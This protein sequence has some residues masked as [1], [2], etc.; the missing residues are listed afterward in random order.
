MHS[1][2]RN[3]H[4]HDYYRWPDG[5]QKAERD[6]EAAAELA[7][8]GGGSE[9]SPLIPA[10]LDEEFPGFVDATATEPPKQLLRSMGGYS[11]ADEEPCDQ[12]SDVHV[13]PDHCDRI[14]VTAN[15]AAPASSNQCRAVSITF[16]ETTPDPA[17]GSTVSAAPR[18][19]YL[20]E[21]MELTNQVGLEVFGTLQRSADLT[22]AE[23]R[24]VFPRVDVDRRGAKRHERQFIR[25][26]S[27]PRPSASLISS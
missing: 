21:A 9:E 1:E 2:N 27:Q 16:A 7:E 15:L 19:R 22:V 24:C 14:K 25:S 5:T 23:S 4:H 17:S 18:L 6:E 12:Q 13:S 10:Q 20:V 11:E 3:E 26:L 8:S